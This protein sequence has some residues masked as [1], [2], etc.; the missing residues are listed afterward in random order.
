MKQTKA[1]VL[2]GTGIFPSFDPPEWITI[3]RPGFA[4][5]KRD[6]NDKQNDEKYGKGNWRIVHYFDRKFLDHQGAL[7]VYEDSYYNHLMENTDITDWLVSM[8]RDIYDN[9]PSNVES[10]LNYSVQ[11]SSSNH[12]QDIAIRRALKRMERSFQGEELVQ[13]RGKKSTGSHLSPGT[14]PFHQSESILQPSLK[15]WW[16]KGTIE[17]FWQSNKL[18][19]VR[20]Y[21]F[22]KKSPPVLVLVLRNDLKLGKGKF[23]AQAAHGVVTYTFLSPK[24]GKWDDKW[25]KDK[26]I[27]IWAVKD[28]DDLKKLETTCRRL[29]VNTVMIRDAGHTQIPA[30][31]QT[32]LAVGPAPRDY[33]DLILKSCDGWTIK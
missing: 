24:N 10:G 12:Y 28:L 25:E 9:D 14:V 21:V 20:G 4:G 33:L 31:T 6:L 23:A 2:P 13:V 5:K 32:C 19:Q 18:L 30:G 11:E 8:A 1:T 26:K 15:G 29:D 7:Q 3:S 27:N 17:D 22:L 16:N